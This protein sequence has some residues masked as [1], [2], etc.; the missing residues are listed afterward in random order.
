MTKIQK[1]KKI[2]PIM[3][4]LVILGSIIVAFGNTVFLTP[5]NIN[6]GGLNGIG[7]IVMNFCSE[8]SKMIVYNIVIY[9]LSIL[10]WGVGF[11]FIGKEF[12]IKT[13][14]STIVFPFATSL[15][16]VIPGTKDFAESITT[17]L[18]KYCPTPNN[19]DIGAY[20]LFSM[21]GGVIVG[22]GV[23]VTFMGGGS[24]GGV[25]VITF[26]FEKYLNIK[27]SI[28][29]F[30]I[31]G[32]VVAIGM[33]VL[34][35]GA[36]DIYLLPCLVGI[37]SIAI[38]ALMIDIVFIKFQTVYQVD[39]ISKQWEDISAYVQNELERGATII[40]VKGGYK[41]TDK[42]MLRV[43]LAKSQIDELQAYIASIDDKAF[44]TIT[45]TKAVFGEGFKA[46]KN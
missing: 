22:F 28:A 26:I 18:L 6:A 45:T 34:C 20:M 29:S 37:L 36:A 39:I 27:Q 23:A 32:L 24:T 3:Y 17:I 38:S 30:L 16:T 40:P 8:S 44:V 7:I 43:V 11:I 13:L 1:I 9:A 2:R 12:A 10:L 33:C 19:P 14:V 42:I 35:P 25:D 5:L 15:F 41:H 31:D 4:L 21:V 46:H